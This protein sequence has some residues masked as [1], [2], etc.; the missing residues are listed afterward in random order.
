VS[1]I[2]RAEKN[3][4]TNVRLWITN[5]EICATCDK[6]ALQERDERMESERDFD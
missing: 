2:T 5:S 4:K 6:N 3:V 1:N